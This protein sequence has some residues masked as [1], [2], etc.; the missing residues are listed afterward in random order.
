MI[1]MRYEDIIGNEVESFKKIFKHYG[2][3]RKLQERGIQLAEQNSLKNQ[4]TG[5]QQHTRKGTTEQWKEEFTPLI[6]TLFK[7]AYSDLLIYLGY[8]QDVNW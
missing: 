3:N 4:S 2:F 7:E 5:S 6:K 8:E 1:E